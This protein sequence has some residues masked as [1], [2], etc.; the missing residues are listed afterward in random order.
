MEKVGDNVG[1]K[2]NWGGV[3]DRPRGG[4]A[5]RRKSPWVSTQPLRKT[6]VFRGRGGVIER[7][8]EKKIAN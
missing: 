4:G 6:T 3:K 5:K 8:K 1:R 7:E 2:D